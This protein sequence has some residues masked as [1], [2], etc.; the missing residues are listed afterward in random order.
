MKYLINEQP[1]LGVGESETENSVSLTW[2]S[3][4]SPIHHQPTRQN[5]CML[6]NH[7]VF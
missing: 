1:T 5:C 4:S 6:C 2:S 7:F 3:E